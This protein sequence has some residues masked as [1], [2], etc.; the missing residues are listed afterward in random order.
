MNSGRMPKL[1]QSLRHYNRQTFTA[2]L[3]AGITVG[4]V[5]LPLAMAFAIS[6]GVAPETGLYCAVVAGFLISALGGSQVQ[7]GGPTGAFVVIVFAIVAE[8]GLN[9]LFV[10][11]IMAGIILVVLGLTGLGSAVKFIPRPVVIGFTNGI[12][13]L[14]ASTQIK[15]FFG[16][17]IENVPGEFLGRMEAIAAHFYTI[18]IPATLLATAAMT[19]LIV[20]RKYLKRIPGAIV[21]LFLG[22]VGGGRYPVDG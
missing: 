14:I 7:I 18:S 11:T 21:V 15:D 13:V 10:C 6:S 3:I 8:H 4:L 5:A 19:V 12:A 22:T 9:G 1:I 16:L 2:D 20:C 17:R